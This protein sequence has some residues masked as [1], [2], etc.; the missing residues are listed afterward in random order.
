MR[1]LSHSPKPVPCSFFVVVVSF[2]AWNDV[3]SVWGRETKSKHADGHVSPPRCLPSFPPPVAT[4]I[5]YSVTAT[6]CS[7]GMVTK[8]Y[9]SA[10]ALILQYV[11]CKQS[12]RSH[13]SENII[14]FPHSYDVVPFGVVMP[15]ISSKSC[16]C[17][18]TELCI[19]KSWFFDPRFF[20][21]DSLIHLKSFL[22]FY[23]SIMVRR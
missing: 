12:R 10:G 7:H 16:R 3:H 13:A 14:P 23:R 8:L 5:P 17:L 9:R 1:R 22:A 19:L 20:I 18:P 21:L 15:F 6:G 11:V 4:P 2:D